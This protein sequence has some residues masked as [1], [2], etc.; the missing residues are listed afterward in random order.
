MPDRKTFFLK[1]KLCNI[2]GTVSLHLILCVIFNL[3]VSFRTFQN[4]MLIQNYQA[5]IVDKRNREQEPTRRNTF[6]PCVGSFTCQA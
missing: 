5:G 1:Q 4:F 2:G 6:I 3:G